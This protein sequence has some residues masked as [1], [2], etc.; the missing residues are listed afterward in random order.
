VQTLHFSASRRPAFPPRNVHAAA[1]GPTAPRTLRHNLTLCEYTIMRDQAASMHGRG[2][3]S[4]VIAGACR[5]DVSQVLTWLVPC[6]LVPTDGPG[7]CSA[8]NSG[9]RLRGEGEGEGTHG[10]K[11]ILWRARGMVLHACVRTFAHHDCFSDTA[12]SRLPMH[13]LRIGMTAACCRIFSQVAKKR[14]AVAT[15]RIA[16]LCKADEVTNRRL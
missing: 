1:C 12:D 6:T 13:L 3:M 16:A 5:H 14:P 7:S 2:G 9:A 10:S 11:L 4:R 15:L 8:E